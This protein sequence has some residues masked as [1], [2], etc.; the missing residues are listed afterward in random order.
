MAAS[1]YG[2]A[3]NSIE[4]SAEKVVKKLVRIQVD[5]G[6]IVLF[7]TFNDQLN[8]KNLNLYQRSI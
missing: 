8:H 6:N 2:R 1:D 7:L 3:K 5:M 4:W